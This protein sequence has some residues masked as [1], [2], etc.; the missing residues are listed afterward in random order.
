MKQF[1]VTILLVTYFAFSS[2]ATIS[3]H[4]CMGKFSSWGLEHRNDGLC[5]RCGMDKNEKNNCCKDEYKKIQVEKDHKAAENNYDFSSINALVPVHHIGNGE[6]LYYTPGYQ[7]SNTI[8]GPPLIT[9]IPVYLF[10][11]TFLI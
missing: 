9:D 5:S 1:A 4:Y 2:G 6:I 8:H 10:D 11:C 3:I 7:I